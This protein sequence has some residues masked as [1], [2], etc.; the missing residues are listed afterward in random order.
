[1]P[2]AEDPLMLRSRAQRGVSKHE[3]CSAAPSFETRAR[4][5]ELRGIFQQ[6]RSSG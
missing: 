1:M 6:A 4:P 2:H 3:G 5:F